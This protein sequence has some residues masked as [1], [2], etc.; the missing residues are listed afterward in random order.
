MATTTNKAGRDRDISLRH[1]VAT[2]A[3]RGAKAL[4]GAPA[5]FSGFRP[6]EG[7]RS[8][9]QILAHM[10]D[11]LDWALSQ[12]QGKEHWRNSK[13]QS[14]SEDTRR[15]FA[16]LTAFDDYL[17]SDS[18][19]HA[20]PEKL[21]QGAIADA[22]THTGQIAMLRR[23]AGARVRGEN[24]SLAQIEVGR[25]GADQNKPVSEFG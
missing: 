14:W 19:L 11:L 9:G 24:Y 16:A 20:A 10:G 2:L 13:P 23:L 18:K 7:S 1:A 15:F 4:K 3:Y 5:E 8:A 17:A 25:T 21:F 6:G 22:L 12:A